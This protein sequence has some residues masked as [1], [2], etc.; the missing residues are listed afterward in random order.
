MDIDV[1]LGS[2]ITNL[3][4]ELVINPNTVRATNV[5]DMMARVRG[6]LQPGQRIN[7][8]RIF[9]YREQKGQPLTL[10]Y[11]AQLVSLRELFDPAGSVELFFR[12]S[13]SG[14]Q[15]IPQKQGGSQPS[16][17]GF[18]FGGFNTARQVSAPDLQHLSGL[19]GVPVL[20]G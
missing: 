6:K 10:S 7:R 16:V 1:V 9:G 19:L 18:G 17:G 20:I 5:L 14:G 3:P 2:Q 8:L 15:I 4:H 11:S 12:P 13:G